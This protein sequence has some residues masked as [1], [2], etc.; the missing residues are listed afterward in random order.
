MRPGWPAV[1]AAG[2]FVLVLIG[3]ISLIVEVPQPPVERT[4]RVVTDTGTKV[5]SLKCYP[6]S[7]DR[8]WCEG[9]MR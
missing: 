4:V 3:I 5:I 6:H 7:G 9:Y 2:F 8:T 1:I